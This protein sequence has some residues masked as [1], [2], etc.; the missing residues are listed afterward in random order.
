MAKA[1][2][3]YGAVQGLA[4]AA[5][6][7]LGGFLVD[8]DL[9]GLGWRTIFWV[10]VPV[11]VV[12]LVAGG[13]FL[14]ESS[15]FRRTALDLTGVAL[16]A[17]AVLLILLPLV[18]GMD[19]GWPWWGFALMAAGVAVMG[20]FLRHE[21]RLATLGGTP[22]LDPALLGVRSFSAG[23]L[24]SLFFFGAIGDF[25]LTL[26]IYLQ[27]G[28]GRTATGTGLVILPYAIGSMLTSGL[29]VALAARAGRTLLV[30]GSLTL[31][32]S[33]AVLWFV[34]R[35]GQETGYWSLAVALLIGGLGLGLAA[36]ILVNVV[37]AGVPRRDAGAAGGVLTTVT[38]IGGAVGIAV[39]GTIFFTKLA[40]G[41]GSRLQVHGDAFSLVLLVEVALY[42]VAAALMLL[43]PR[44]AAAYEG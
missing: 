38:Q 30:G 7:L 37:L 12:A 8:A 22:L 33:Q 24:A 40:S 44:T 3:A 32:V 9:G 11:A 34:V 1:F 17:A 39:L 19:W 20:A 6:P 2:G 25:F 41:E 35:D 18:Q 43:L 27:S 36:P 31:A 21:R 14:P 13:R 28:T 15:A 16:S 26:S 4:A 5:G 23:L 42:V 10:N 29:G